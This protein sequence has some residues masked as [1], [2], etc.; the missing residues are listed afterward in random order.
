MRQLA[1]SIVGRVRL[2][3]GR[4]PAC[5]SEGARHAACGVC[6]GYEGPFPASESTQHRWAWRFEHRPVP[7]RTGSSE[8]LP[9]L[10]YPAA[11]HPLH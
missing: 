6:K 10:S 11:S 2:A 5:A 7:A 8:A 4:C 3:R 1:A 9:E